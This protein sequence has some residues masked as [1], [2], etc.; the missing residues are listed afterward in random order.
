M[1]KL[2][3][4]LMNRY[5]P[6]FQAKM[7]EDEPGMWRASAIVVHGAWGIYHDVVA[8]KR[9]YGLR[10]AYLTA[11]W[12]ALKA[13]WKR[14]SFLSN[15]GINY[16]VEKL[17]LNSIDI[18]ECLDKIKVKNLPDSVNPET[19]IHLLDSGA[20]IEWNYIEHLWSLVL[21]NRESTTFET[22]N[23]LHDV[24]QDNCYAR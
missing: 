11:R 2:Q 16:G 5:C 15:S 19:V 3:M 8:A 13:Q 4:W 21:P 24:L 12:L 22:L 23:E 10:N 7:P 6:E 1:N 14:P 17:E 20:T 9:V 18:Q